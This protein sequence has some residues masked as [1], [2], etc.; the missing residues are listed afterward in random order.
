MQVKE[1]TTNVAIRATGSTRSGTGST[2]NKTGSNCHI[3]ENQITRSEEMRIIQ[4]TSLEVRKQLQNVYLFYYAV[5]T[6]LS[7]KCFI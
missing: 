6:P 5:N 1:S 2:H 4:K 3:I 7:R